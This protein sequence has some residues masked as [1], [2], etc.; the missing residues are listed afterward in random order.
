MQLAFGFCVNVLPHKFNFVE[1]LHYLSQGFIIR[2][3]VIHHFSSQNK[4]HAFFYI[5]KIRTIDLLILSN[6][7]ANSS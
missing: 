1:F 5:L 6:V 4:K 2:T 3:I 7:L